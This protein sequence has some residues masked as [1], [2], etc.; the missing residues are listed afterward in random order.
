MEPKLSTRKNTIPYS[1]ARILI[2][3]HLQGFPSPLAPGCF[4][5]CIFISELFFFTQKAEVWATVAGS[6]LYKG[7]HYSAVFHEDLPLMVQLF[8]TSAFQPSGRGVW[9]Q[10]SCSSLKS[11]NLWV[12]LCPHSS[13]ANSNLYHRSYLQG[14]WE[15]H[16]LSGWPSAQLEFHYCLR[17]RMDRANDHPLSFFPLKLCEQRLPWQSVAGICAPN[18]G[19]GFGSW[20]EN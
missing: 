7:A 12:N 4:L 14:G 5:K 13:H 9:T 16:F 19:P 1:S 11:T 18:A 3:T 8:R 6:S 2:I 20:S 15:M 17:R 10:K